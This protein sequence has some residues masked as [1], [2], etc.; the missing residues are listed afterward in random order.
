M[1]ATGSERAALH[2]WP[3]A[4]AAQLCALELGAPEEV[5]GGAVGPRADFLSRGSGRPGTVGC[6]CGS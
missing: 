4:L 3:V 6:P 5:S 1:A 2:G